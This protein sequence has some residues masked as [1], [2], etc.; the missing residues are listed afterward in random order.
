LLPDWPCGVGTVLIMLQQA[1][2]DLAQRSPFTELQKNYLRENFIQTGIAIANQLRQIG[3]CA[4]PF[5]PK[6]GQPLLSKPGP[7]GLDDIA[8]IRAC[9]GY[10]TVQIEG[11][12]IILHPDWGSAVYPSVILSSAPPELVRDVANSVT[13]K[14][15][16]MVS[17]DWC[18][19]RSEYHHSFIG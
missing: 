2:C 6:T 9:L 19:T 14:G 12:S 11:C 5:D 18:R 8:V 13:G 15:G 3:Y 10:P 16:L 1:A 17:D 7:L 4:D